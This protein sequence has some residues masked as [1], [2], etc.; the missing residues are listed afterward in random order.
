MDLFATVTNSYTTVHSSA[1]IMA[2]RVTLPGFGLF[3]CY[4]LS[5]VLHIFSTSVGGCK[6]QLTRVQWEM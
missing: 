4:A 1:L 6:E 3:S 5:T 2:Q